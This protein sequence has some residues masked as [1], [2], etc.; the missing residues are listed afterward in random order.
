[1]SI[2]LHVIFLDPKFFVKNSSGMG[3]PTFCSVNLFVE[4][5]NMSS[6]RGMLLGLP[7][8]NTFR[9]WCSVWQLPE[10]WWPGL[11]L[12]LGVQKIPL[13]WERFFR[14]EGGPE[15]WLVL[16]LEKFLGFKFWVSYICAT[17]FFLKD[18]TGCQLILGRKSPGGVLGWWFK[19]LKLFR[20][21]RVNKN[22]VH[23]HLNQVDLWTFGVHVTIHVSCHWSCCPVR[24]SWVVWCY[25]PYNNYHNTWK[26]AMPKGNEYSNSNH[27][28]SVS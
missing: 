20:E 13:F 9:L 21:I 27:P 6:I 28:F 26:Q 7:S 10:S 25:T 16:K 2:E 15:A 14:G 8:W 18:P 12:G 19:C 23:Q 11:G 3:T 5:K 1:M 4:Q 22:G 17:F 24:F